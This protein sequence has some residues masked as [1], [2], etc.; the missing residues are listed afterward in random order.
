MTT[1]VPLTTAPDIVRNARQLYHAHRDAATRPPKAQNLDR[2]WEALECIREHGG[3]DYCV[4]RS[5]VNA[6]SGG[7]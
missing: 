3:R 2:L 1:S 5:I 4:I 7:S 6:E